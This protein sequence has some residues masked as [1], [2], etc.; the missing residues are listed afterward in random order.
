MCLHV[1]NRDNFAFDIMVPSALTYVCKAVSAWRLW[2]CVGSTGTKVG[3]E[4][5]RAC[6]MSITFTSVAR[7][8]QN[9]LVLGVHL[10]RIQLANY[11]SKQ[12]YPHLAGVSQRALA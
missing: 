6:T 1:E 10:W 12:M 11:S 9:G 2:S 3:C 5:W 4:S 8:S 7:L